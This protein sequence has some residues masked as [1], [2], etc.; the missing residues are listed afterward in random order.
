MVAP[1]D[2][3][4]R[5]SH[6][7]AGAGRQSWRY[8]LAA[9]LAASV[10]GVAPAASVAEQNAPQNAPAVTQPAPPQKQPATQGNRELTRRELRSFDRYLEAHP[11]LAKQLE[12][13]PALANNP[14]FLAKHAGFRKYLN[15]RPRV[16]AQLKEDPHA[17][18]KHYAWY[19]K[20]ERTHGMH[21]KA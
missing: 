9:V 11:K 1:R 13:D 16:M 20:H 19:Q 2:F 7:L 3:V 6:A 18:M 12:H 10:V 15:H 4:K 14:H 5:L 17:F 8:T 21:K